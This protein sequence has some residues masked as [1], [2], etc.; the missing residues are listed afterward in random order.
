MAG[1]ACGPSCG[2]CGGC[3]SQWDGHP[4]EPQEVVT[5]ANCGIVLERV[6]VS[7]LTGQNTSAACC[8]EICA[9]DFMMRTERREARA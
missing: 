7:V 8:S 4:Q 3:T 6:S 1:S 2:W 5:C 9:E